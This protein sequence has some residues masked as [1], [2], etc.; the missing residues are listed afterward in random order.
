MSPAHGLPS[1]EAVAAGAEGL[2]EYA[3]VAQREGLVPIVEPEV[4][5]AGAHTLQECEQA[6]S[7][8]GALGVEED[9]WA[10]A[11]MESPTCRPCRK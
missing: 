5:M 1:A 2:A 6:T 9:R 10:R 4:L 7:Q 3:S 8:V 11:S